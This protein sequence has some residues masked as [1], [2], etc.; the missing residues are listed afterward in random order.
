[1]RYRK[2]NPGDTNKIAKLLVKCFNITSVKEGKETF[3]RERRKDNFIVAEEN[4]KLIGLIS[5][6]MHGLPKHQLV[7]I[8]RIGV[9]AN[10]KRDEVAEELLRTAVQSADKF[11]KKMN[12]KLR[13][14]Y[15]MV[16]SPNIKMRNFYKKMG[17]VEEAKLKDH[18]Y[19]GVDDFILS[20]F[21]E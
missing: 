13:K 3:H 10:P 19:K 1:M 7:R 20:M 8:E 2:A 15:A 11:F 16:H 4:G 6:D 12:L 21:F 9:L 18:Y 17:F 14:I 5:W